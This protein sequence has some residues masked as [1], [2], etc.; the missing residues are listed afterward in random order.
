MKTQ[1]INNLWS[2]SGRINRIQYLAVGSF[3]MAI[4]FLLDRW[5]A[6][7][8]FGTEW[9]WNDYL[10][11]VRHLLLFGSDIDKRFMLMTL[12]MVSL[13]FAWIGLTLTTRRLRDTGLPP[14]LTALFFIPFLNLILFAVCVLLPTAPQKEHQPKAINVNSRNRWAPEGRAGAALLAVGLTSVLG[15]LFTSISVHILETYGWTIFTGVPFTLGLLASLMY[16]AHAA[17]GVGEHI[18]VGLLAAGFAAGFVFLFAIEGLVCLLMAAPIWVPCTVV[19]SLFGAALISSV[20]RQVNTGRFAL[21]LIISVPGIMG[22]EAAE[23]RSIPLRSVESRIIIAAEPSI[24]WHQVITFPPL[25]SPR[26]ILFR[27]GIAYPIRARIEG[28][29][30]GAVRYCEFS[31]GPFVEPITVWDQPNSLAFDVVAQPRPMNEWS[32]YRDLDP[33]H[34]HGFMTSER[35]QFELLALDNGRTLL[36]GTT[37]YRQDI[38]P[39]A[40]WAIWSDYIIHR[41]HH[42]VLTHIKTQSEVTLGTQE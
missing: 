28:T 7:S 14:L 29:G 17:R 39:N 19:G 2:F 42:Q 40:Y 33:A 12:L 36:I 13:P 16:G 22:L 35:G 1:P 23:N 8:L 6:G 10:Y 20:H 37:W 21:I 3:A 5:L 41:I 15:V 27:S 9:R 34:L 11:P 18:V 31:T 4:K 38:W 32:I 24:V 25:E 26:E 30:V